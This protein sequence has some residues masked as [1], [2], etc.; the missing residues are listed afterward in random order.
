[1]RHI[2]TYFRRNVDSNIT[3]TDTDNCLFWLFSSDQL[4]CLYMGL[5]L[6]SHGNVLRTKITTVVWVMCCLL[7]TSLEYLCDCSPLKITEIDAMNITKGEA[8][9]QLYFLAVSLFLCDW[10]VVCV[11]SCSA[12]KPGH[13]QSLGLQQSGQPGRDVQWLGERGRQQRVPVHGL[14]HRQSR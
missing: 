7:V 10:L 9:I 14:T 8:V 12:E 3:F 2:V 4:L 6:L 1:M 11:L 5:A 13:A